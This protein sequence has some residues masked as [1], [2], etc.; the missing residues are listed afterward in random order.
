MNTVVLSW[1]GDSVGDGDS[2]EYSEGTLVLFWL[3]VEDSVGDG[4]S[5]EYTVDITVLS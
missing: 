1:L 3:R 5:V 4:D 2:V